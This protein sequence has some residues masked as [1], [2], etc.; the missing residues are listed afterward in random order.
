MLG[1]FFVVY[2]L[3]TLSIIFIDQATKHLASEKIILGQ[4]KN[5]LN[6]KLF[7][8]NTRNRGAAYGF[9]KDRPKLLTCFT[10]LSSLH[11]CKVFIELITT[12]KNNKIFKLAF[13]FL[14][15]GAIGNIYDRIKNKYVVDFICIKFS[16]NAPIFNVADFFIVIGVVITMFKITFN[17]IIRFIKN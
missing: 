3:I 1:G 10:T 13:A 5:F 2:I 4:R 17:L 15:G 8:T 12:E 7:I 9:L 14:L 16:K 11:I 6:N